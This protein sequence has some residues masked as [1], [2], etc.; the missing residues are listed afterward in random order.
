M[1]ICTKV[2]SL[3]HDFEIIFSPT[4]KRPYQLNLSV[5][6]RGTQVL[7]L[8]HSILY[9]AQR[10]ICQET[11][12]PPQNGTQQRLASR[13]AKSSPTRAIALRLALIL[14]MGLGVMLPAQAQTE[15]LPE[16]PVM[17][18]LPHEDASFFSPESSSLSDPEL[19]ILRLE[20]LNIVPSA[21]EKPPVVYLIGQASYLQSDNILLSAR[22]PINDGLFRVGAS[23]LAVPQISDRTSLFASVGGNLARYNELTFFDYN[24]FAVNAGIRQRFLA[25]T[26]GV[27]GWNHQQLFTKEGSIRFLDEHSLYG[28]INRRDYLSSEFVF[29]SFIQT[30]ISFAQPET[31]SQFLNTAGVSL[32]YAPSRQFQAFLDYQFLYSQFTQQSRDDLYHQITGRLVYRP[33]QNMRL[34][35]FAGQS[36]GYSTA[37]FIDFDGFVFGINLGVNVP[38]F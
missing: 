15:M 20:A 21:T 29:D 18:L 4:F 10:H 23:L 35:L 14:P 1:K 25:E 11:P 3:I 22:D 12:H 28:E 36:L 17:P 30:R 6:K 5:R 26:Y 33:S 37:E 27:L 13:K 16:V 24:Q 32:G 2:L 8:R 7:K 38:L 31:R 19:G 9:T 34:E